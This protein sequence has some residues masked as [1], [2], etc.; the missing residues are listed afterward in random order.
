MISKTPNFTGALDKIINQL[1]PH[2][3]TC[4]Q[5]RQ[6]FDIFQEDIEFYKTLQVSEPK[7]C[8]E[9]RK[10]NRLAFVNYTTFHKRKC[11]APGHFEKIIS[12]IPENTCFPVYDNDYY[13]SDNWDPMDYGQKYDFSKLFFEQFKTL[14][15]KV[16]QPATT[17]DPKN[18]N[19]EYSSYGVELKDCY[20]IFG[21]LKGEN[22]FYG[23]WPLQ[24]KDSIDVLVI[25]NSE[26]CY[27]TVNIKSCYNC[28][29]SYFS[30]Y[31]LDS[32]FIYDCHNCQNCFGCVN[33]R[34]KKYY[35]FNEPLTKEEY[36]EKIKNIDLGDREILFEYQKRFFK[37]LE[38]L[39]KRNVFNKNISNSIG[40]LL[41]NC[42]NCFKC[43]WIQNSENIRFSAMAINVKDCMDIQGIN[44]NNCYYGVVIMGSRV[45]FSANT[46]DQ[47]LEVEYSI[48]CRNCSYCFGC[49]GLNKKQ[50]CILNKQYSETDYWGLVDSIKTKML[51]D[52]EYGEFFPFCF[53]PFSYNSSMAQI[54]F[55]LT[56][57][58]VK[59]KG[60]NWVEPISSEFQEKILKAQ[61]VPKNIKDISDE[62]LNCI[63]LCEKTKKLFR[64]TKTELEFY[65]KH[66][67]P[68]PVICPAERLRQRFSWVG[69]LNLEET[70]CSKCKAKISVNYRGD[71][72]KNIYCEKCYQSEVA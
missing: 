9:C 35:F 31:C 26:Q 52:D 46:R 22:I 11:N 62:I 37:L 19:S 64:I 15:E 18:I 43:F 6:I 4:Q 12:Q 13:W 29:F 25:A 7:L 20:Y 17:R 30:N 2:Q 50:F 34:N 51:K 60:L 16:P 41:E 47:S 3:K 54:S 68:I 38:K 23:N 70:F 69:S 49:I 58:Q 42:K 24:A 28:Q 14:L 32:I 67:L 57:Q 45:Y 10:Q 27:E 48:N 33:L 66:N 5:C 21:G 72:K 55:P 63:I 56:E 1:K 39:P 44:A 40:T 36:E 71:F 8:P 59:E 61:E 53:S 65:R